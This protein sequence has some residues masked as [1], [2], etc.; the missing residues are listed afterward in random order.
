MLMEVV[1]HGIPFI[2]IPVNYR[3][4]V[5]ESS[6]TGDLWKAFWLGLRM[7]TLVLSYRSGSHAAARVRWDTLSRRQTVPPQLVREPSSFLKSQDDGCSDP[8]TRQVVFPS[9]RQATDSLTYT[10]RPL[11]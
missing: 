10:H 6:V 7:I 11:A 2:E 9:K 4:R 1:A 5:G 8:T 3:R